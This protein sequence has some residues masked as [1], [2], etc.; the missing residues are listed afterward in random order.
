MEKVSLVGPLTFTLKK[1]CAYKPEV[2]IV[3]TYKRLKEEI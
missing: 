3:Q 1:E 2:T